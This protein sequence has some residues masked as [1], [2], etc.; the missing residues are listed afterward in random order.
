MVNPIKGCAE[1]NLHNTNLL[2]TLQGT[3]QCMEYLQKCIT[4][5]Q[6]F[7]ISKLVAWKHTTVLHKFSET[8]RHHTLKHL[9]H[10]LCY[11][12]RLIIGNRGWRWTFRNWGDIGLSPASRK[13]SQ[14]NKPPK[15]TL[16]TGQ[17][18]SSSRKKR[19]KHTQWVSA[20]IRVRVKQETSYRTRPEGKCDKRWILS[21]GQINR[22]PVLLVA[23]IVWGLSD[24][25]HIGTFICLHSQTRIVYSPLV[26]N[27]VIEGN[28]YDVVKAVTWKL[29]RILKNQALF[30]SFEN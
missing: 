12:N 16:K 27:V 11:G 8:N 21:G 26:V 30:W 22:L 14:P 2:P 7:P 4:D 9:S 23:K 28:K 13:T 29:L 15:T 19:W 1:I 3:F 6:T 10:Y 24:V 20:T 18:I 17:N 25:M 5:T